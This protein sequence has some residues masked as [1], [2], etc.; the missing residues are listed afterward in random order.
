MTKNPNANK[1]Q[2]ILNRQ[3]EI[4]I[5]IREVLIKHNIKPVF[6][7]GLV[8]G[9]VR[10]NDF[11]RWDFDADFFIVAEDVIG[12]EKEI[13]SD[14]IKKGFELITTRNTLHDWKIAVEKEDYHID[15]RSFF[16][17]GKNH[18][19]KVRRSNGDYSI[20]IMPCRFMD[21]LQEIEFYG[22]KYFIP[23]D[24]DGYLTHLYGDWRTPIRSVKHSEY[25]SSDFKKV[26]KI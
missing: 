8:L 11:I 18:V 1:S 4:L 13:I 24:T 12:K 15:L 17:D 5:E 20:Y 9:Y 7:D 23:E 3:G 6:S 2:D 16:R 19:S 22:G 25:L 26:V 14:L 10:E 21:N